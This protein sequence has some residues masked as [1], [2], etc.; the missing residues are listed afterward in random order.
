M[1]GPGSGAADAT[2]QRYAYSSRVLAGAPVRVASVLLAAGFG[3][4][5][6]AT[7]STGGRAGLAAGGAAVLM[8]TVWL[9][10]VRML[11]G[12]G[13]VRVGHGPLGGYEYAIPAARV[14]EARV[15]TVTWPQVFGF[16]LP[17]GQRDIRMTVRPGPTLV[18]TLD[19]G[20]R[21]RISVP[22]PALAAR[23]LTATPAEGDPS[24]KPAAREGEDAF[25]FGPKRLGW[26]LRPRTWQAW[27]PTVLAI[28][29]V[30][31][32]HRYL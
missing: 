5:A 26:G 6:A 18:L 10:T 29:L 24:P 32:L 15:T 16:G 20:V 31:A 21:M 17:T 11:L 30:V 27:T 28:V 2:A 12:G 4:A 22:D 3:V 7:G 23:L 25:W 13:R 1:T 14:A 19:D 8:V 9:G